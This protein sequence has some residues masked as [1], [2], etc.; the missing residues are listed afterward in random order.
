VTGR[1]GGGPAV[2]DTPI[3]VGAVDHK[4]LFCRTLLETFEPYE[5]AQIAWPEL[6]DDARQRL[7][8]LPIWD[9]AVDTEERASVNVLGYAE[10]IGDP[11]VKQATELNGF[12]EA[13]HKRVL[14]GLIAA[15][16]INLP[17]A[18]PYRKP[19]AAE[20]AFM[21]TGYS[22]C[23]DS[24]F[25]FGL[26]EV[27]KRS[28]YFPGALVDIFE[29]I[30]QEECRHILFFVNWAAWH[31]RTMSWWRRRLFAAKVLGVW[32]FLLW[33]RIKTARA[34]NG[35]NNFTATGHASFN[36]DLGP[37]ALLDVCLVENARRMARYD[38]R[39][40][41]PALAPT[42]ARIARDLLRLSARLARRVSRRARQ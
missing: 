37:A 35:G 40:L 16:A 4:A 19:R 30:M 14:A 42:L 15:Y 29:P 31:R 13:R 21:V 12:E 2:V 34:V 33:E 5:P 17:P 25:A 32:G 36:V 22:E 10:M 28:G 11:L 41:R 1:A 26:F 7:V 27:A 9:I 39:L 18:Q 8:G 20:W 3:A 23:I 38:H 6:D 24:F